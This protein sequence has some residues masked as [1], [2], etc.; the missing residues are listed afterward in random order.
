MK[1][2]PPAGKHLA[3]I[4]DTVL[5]A[6]VFRRDQRIVGDVDRI[7]LDVVRARFERV[8]G[9][10]HP[11]LCGFQGRIGAVQL[12]L[13]LVLHFLGLGAPLYEVGGAIEF[14]LRQQH[15]AGLLDDVGIGFFDRLLRLPHLGFGFLQ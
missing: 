1:T 2:L 12:L 6:A 13:T 15:L 3:D 4:G 8:L 9:F 14:L 5:D 11:G 10:G 7:E